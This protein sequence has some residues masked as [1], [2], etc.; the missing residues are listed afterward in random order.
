M[1]ILGDSLYKD[2]QEVLTGKDTNAKLIL[3]K[4]G[5][6]KLYERS[7]RGFVYSVDPKQQL[8]CP[9]NN[10]KDSLGLQQPFLCFQMNLCGEHLQINVEVIV[11]DSLKRKRRIIF[12]TSFQKI[13]ANEL[14]CQI[15]FRIEYPQNWHTL[16]FDIGT[17]TSG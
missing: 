10:S 12:S 4:F 11:K 2:F 9:V 1:R 5:L 6:S 17:V 13:M 3:P 14:H 15:P 16:I 8:N 7:I